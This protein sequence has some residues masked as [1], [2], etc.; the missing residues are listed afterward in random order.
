MASWQKPKNTSTTVPVQ[1]LW[2]QKSFANAI[3]GE[4]SGAASS[5]PQHADVAQ[6]LQAS[7]MPVSRLSPTSRLHSSEQNSVSS[8]LN[9]INVQPA[10]NHL[11][12]LQQRLTE[13]QRNLREIDEA[14]HKLDSILHEDHP[15]LEREN[16]EKTRAVSSEQAETL[17]KASLSLE[18]EVRRS[19]H[20]KELTE[21]INDDSDDLFN[22]IELERVKNAEEYEQQ[23]RQEQNKSP[24][25]SSTSS[26]SENE[27]DRPSN[28]T[29]E[30]SRTPTMFNVNA[31][32]F[33]PSSKSPK[34][35]EPLSHTSFQQLD[36]S[37][38]KVTYHQPGFT[39]FY[40]IRPPMSNN[41][42]M[43]PQLYIPQ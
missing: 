14:I 42:V 8:G 20:L 34:T 36:P 38:Q 25:A 23:L 9:L 30:P 17:R 16:L 3:R 40:P 12:T 31:S 39:L 35:S 21:E 22:L 28:T 6:L 26:S 43:L 11:E 19:Q 33:K 27:S 13:T 32:E 2:Q 24:S 7:A 10:F 29:P 37:T 41:V 18:R 4:N 1:S 5:G 15:K